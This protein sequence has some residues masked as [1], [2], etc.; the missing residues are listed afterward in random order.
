MNTINDISTRLFSVPLREQM[1]DALHGIHTHFELITTTIALSNGVAGTGYSYT[2]GKGGYAIKAMIDHDLTPYLMGKDASKIKELNDGMQQHIHYVGRGGIASFA[3]SATDIALWDAYCKTENKPLWQLAGGHDSKTNAYC[4]GIDL[5]FSKEK[6][7]SNIKGYLE[8]GVNAVKI[9]IGKEDLAED[10]DRI[11]SVRE[12]IGNDIVFMVDANC[13]YSVEKAVKIA[14][15]FEK[16]NIFWFEEPIIPDDYEGYAHIAKE[17]NID[18]ASGE[19]YHTEFEFD[20]AFSTSKLKYIQP[21]V[22]NCCGISGWLDV[23]KKAKE[24]N[25]KVCSHGAQELSVSL[26]ASQENAGWVEIHSFYID[27]YIT[28]PIKIE[29]Y[30]IHASNKPGIGIEF[31][32]DKL[33]E[34]CNN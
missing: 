4:G 12:L 21:D 13:A 7:L 19:N 34:A 5:D 28:H 22:C 30:K 32:W 23:A 1:G 26:V 15:E 27:D 11:K 25:I 8:T 10:L 16:Y 20:L 33:N 6:L 18:L 31:N 2:G 17:T 24:K 3:I 29:D 9:K 14:N